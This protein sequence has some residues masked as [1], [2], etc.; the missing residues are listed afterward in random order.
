MLVT[1]CHGSMLGI[2]TNLTHNCLHTYVP[3]VANLQLIDLLLIIINCCVDLILIFMNVI[4][5]GLMHLHN[6]IGYRSIITATP[7]L[8]C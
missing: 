5:R 2:F 3:C 8:P 1:H 7:L 4:Q 6:T